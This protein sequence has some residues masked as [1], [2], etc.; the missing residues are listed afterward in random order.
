M[1]EV[2]TE[3]A[4][5]LTEELTE[6]LTDLYALSGRELGYLEAHPTSADLALLKR[7][8]AREERHRYVP[9]AELV[10]GAAARGWRVRLKAL[11]EHPQR[12]QLLRELPLPSPPAQRPLKELIKFKSGTLKRERPRAALSCPWIKISDFTIDDL[13]L[14]VDR[15]IEDHLAVSRREASNGLTPYD[16][17]LLTKGLHFGVY[18]R[19]ITTPLNGE[20]LQGEL[21]HTAFISLKTEELHPDVVHPAYLA[22]YLTSEAGYRALR[23]LQDKHQQRSSKQKLEWS[24]SIKELG[25]LLVPLPSPLRQACAI[26]AWAL[27]AEL[28]RQQQQLRR[29]LGRYERHAL[30]ALCGAPLTPPLLGSPSPSK[31][32]TSTTSTLKAH[33]THI[34]QLSTLTQ[35]FDSDLPLRSLELCE[36]PLFPTVGR[37]VILRSLAR[38]LMSVSALGREGRAWRALHVLVSVSP[39]LLESVEVGGWLQ[40]DAPQLSAEARERELDSQGV[41]LCSVALQQLNRHLL[42]SDERLSLPRHTPEPWFHF[43]SGASPQPSEAT[44]TPDLLMVFWGHPRG[45]SPTLGRIITALNER[46]LSQANP[47][48][49]GAL[50]PSTLLTPAPRLSLRSLLQLTVDQ[51]F[52]RPQLYMHDLGGVAQLEGWTL[53]LGV[54]ELTPTEVPSADHSGVILGCFERMTQR[55]QPT[56]VQ[57]SLQALWER[58]AREV[59]AQHSPRLSF[60]QEH[61]SDLQQQL[62]T[63]TPPPL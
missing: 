32:S 13:S 9:I 11:R 7:L 57:L 25:E 17:L 27:R 39:R 8:K 28:T 5:K 38:H 54:Y 29:A 24:L 16:L 6:E 21:A 58:P 31:T 33:H 60:H 20:V 4:D 62:F 42:V 22:A 50:S 26:S 34:A 37:Y 59:I 14:F 30:S 45:E 35:P 52:E 36:A 55:L 53:Y 61:L 48:L 18:M 63:L 46:S 15:L 47:H 51:H 43:I 49:N 56:P 19:P 10:H 12:A 44:P 41:N 1:R 40:G 2:H 3:L 23:A